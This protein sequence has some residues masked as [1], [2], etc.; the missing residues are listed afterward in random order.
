ML[1]AKDQLLS[2]NW[3]VIKRHGAA[4]TGG[5]VTITHDGAFA[6]CMCSEHVAMLNLETG[7]V[8]RLIPDLTQVRTRPAAEAERL[9][10]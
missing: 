6:A 7:M 3:A 2:K 9:H 10:A 1:K 5:P 4:Y 8:E